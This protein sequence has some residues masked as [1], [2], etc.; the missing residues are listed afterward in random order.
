MAV[1]PRASFLAA[2][3]ADPYDLAT[4]KVYADWLEEFGTFPGDDDEAVLQ[5]GWTKE[6]QEAKEWLKEFGQSINLT[7]DEVIEAMNDCAKGSDPRQLEVE[8]PEEVEA[9]PEQLWERW[10]IIT[11]H[12]IPTTE[13]PF[14]GEEPYSC[15]C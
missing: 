1:D 8:L 6:K 11:G 10:S 13:C 2:I 5:R 15:S 7:A 4:R 14:E 12:V 3:A 9:N